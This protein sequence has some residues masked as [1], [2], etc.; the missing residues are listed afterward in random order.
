M[1]YLASRNWRDYGNTI[2]DTNNWDGPDWGFQASDRVYPFMSYYEL[3]AR[4]Q[5]G[6]TS[7]AFDLLRREWG[8]MTRVGPGTMWETIGPYGGPPVDGHPSYD[9]GWSSGGAPALT[10]YVLGVTPTSPGF[11]TFTVTPQA[12]DLWWASGDV[13]TPHGTI[14]V[15]WRRVGLAVLLRVTAPSGT[16][17]T[18]RP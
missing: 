13:P 18:N 11:A 2:A 3:S 16:R 5:L 4:F 17:W 15:S 1:N 9:S 6:L 8:Y 14:H 12:N 10:Q 7:T